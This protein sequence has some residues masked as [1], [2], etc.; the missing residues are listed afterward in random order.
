MLLSS[1]Y[2]FPMSAAQTSVKDCTIVQTLK[3]DPS[4]AAQKYFD[5]QT[6][7]NKKRSDAY[8]EGG[9]WFLLWD[10]LS[11][12]IV[13]VIMLSVGLSNWIKKIAQKFRNTNIQ[14]LI[15]TALYI[16]FAYVIIFPLNVYKD[17]IR[18]HQYNLSNL[19]FSSWFGED[20]KSLGLVIVFGSLL[21]MLIYLIIR[22]V[23]RKWWIWGSIVTVIF[24]FIAVFISPIYIAP[25]FNDYKPLPEGTLKNEI[26]SLARANG[27]P[28]SEV[29]QFNASKQSN[30]ISANV[31]GFASTIRISL[32]DNL[33]NQC[34]TSEIKAVVGHEIGHYVMH[35]IGIELIFIGLI[36]FMGY[37]LIDWLFDHLV[38]KFGTK[39]GIK[40]LSDIG[41]L[42]LLLLLFVLFSFIITPI[43][44]NISRTLE[45]EAD[46]YGLN[47][48]GEP[49]GFASVAMKLSTYR[50]INPGRWEEIIFY[51]HPSGKTRV[52]N[53][54]KWKAEHL[55][56]H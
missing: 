39:W 24:M 40:E 17:F 36:I 29:Y 25:L 7:E 51:D 49:D 35:H 34:T 53:A 18:E 13:A 27:V 48:A 3:F 4:S 37:Y 33:L 50:K 10:L 2:S 55:N 56:S 14:N 42:P 11:Y 54:M 44:N 12:I 31:S 21:I 19:S 16:L 6:Q 5:T 43:D 41:S 46:Y 23:K 52:L 38:R 45:T 15:Y 30:R 26:L 1:L 8:F 28:A 47:A 9:Y 20:M 32:N 22:K